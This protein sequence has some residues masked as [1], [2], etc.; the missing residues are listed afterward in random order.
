ML[1]R[2]MLWPCVCVCLSVCLSQSGMYYIEMAEYIGL[3]FGKG[4]GL[5][6][7]YW[8]TIFGYLQYKDTSCDTLLQALMDFGKFRDDRHK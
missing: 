6:L 1:V 8:C 5:G 7:S 4:Y 2:Y 3:I